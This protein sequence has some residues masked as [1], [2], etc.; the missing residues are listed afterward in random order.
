M[1]VVRI[2]L[3]ALILVVLAGC[4]TK[5]FTNRVTV[6]TP[7]VE[8]VGVM[9]LSLGNTRDYGAEN[10][11]VAGPDRPY[12][13]TLRQTGTKMV[14]DGSGLREIEFG[15]VLPARNDAGYFYVRFT[16]KPGTQQVDVG[17]IA[18]DP[19]NASATA[20][21]QGVR[22]P[23]SITSTADGD[24]WGITVELPRP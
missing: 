5:V 8:P 20:S 2:L 1:R 10:T 14:F 7:V 11:R 24:A 18:W 12:T 16:P 19:P 6:Q 21:P 15:L 13:I 17:L 22:L 3:V 9:D 23:L 4:G